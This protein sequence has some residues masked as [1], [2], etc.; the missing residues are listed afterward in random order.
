MNNPLIRRLEVR[1][2]QKTKM[3]LNQNF[4]KVSIFPKQHRIL[5]MDTSVEWAH[6]AFCKKC[7]AYSVNIFTSITSVSYCVKVQMHSHDSPVVFR[8]QSGTLEESGAE[9]AISLSDIVPSA[10]NCSVSWFQTSGS[11]IKTFTRIWTFFKLILFHLVC[12]CRCE[13]KEWLEG[14]SEPS[15]NL[16]TPLVWFEVPELKKKKK[17]PQCI[18]GTKRDMKCLFVCCLCFFCTIWWCNWAVVSRH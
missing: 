6:K 17:I 18:F 9:E 14:C 2:S 3:F 7:S 15:W 1:P 11:A 12:R 5:G 16:I 8:A 4:R 10:S 13:E